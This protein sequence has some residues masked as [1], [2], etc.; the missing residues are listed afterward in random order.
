LAKGPVGIV[1]TVFPIAGWTVA[2]RSVGRVYTRL[3]WLSG[4]A[5]TLLMGVPW[6]VLAE[7]KTPG[8]LRYYLVGEHFLRYVQSDWPG[9][10]YGSAHARPRGTIWFYL[11]MVTLPWIFL[12]PAA[13]RSVWRRGAPFTPDRRWQVFFL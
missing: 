3:P 4:T 7:W 6:F 13:V 11:L 8:F 1:L 2:F 5:L 9:D 12:I 10:L